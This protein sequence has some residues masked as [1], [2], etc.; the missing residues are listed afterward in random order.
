MINV[1]HI[2]QQVDWLFQIIDSWVIALIQFL[3]HIDNRFPANQLLQ[4]AQ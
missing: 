1:P 2:K 4:F 3:G